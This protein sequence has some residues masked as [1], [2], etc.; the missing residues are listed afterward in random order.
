MSTPD[1]SQQPVP[2]QPAQGYYQQP[3]AG[4]P[5]PGPA[6]S[7]NVNS[8]PGGIWTVILLLVGFVFTAF[9]FIMGLVADSAKVYCAGAALTGGLV[10]L[11]LG[12]YA[13][14]IGTIKK[15]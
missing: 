5:A 15:K 7:V 13:A 6:V 2:Q 3:P 9:G 11:G 14:A 12:L 1:Y 8:F 4:Y 10:V